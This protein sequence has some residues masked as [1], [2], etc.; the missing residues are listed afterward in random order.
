MRGTW[1]AISNLLGVTGPSTATRTLE[2]SQ[3][4]KDSDV[5]SAAKHTTAVIILILRFTAALAVFTQFTP[6]A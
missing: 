1:K 2:A 6:T 5:P 4:A 3:T